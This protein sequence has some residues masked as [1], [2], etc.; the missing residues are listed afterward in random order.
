[1]LAHGCDIPDAGSQLLLAA[2]SR[3][4]DFEAWRSLLR[5]QNLT[6]EQAGD[7]MLCFVSCLAQAP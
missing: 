1:M 2:L 6:D 3:A 7:L 5:R 4:L